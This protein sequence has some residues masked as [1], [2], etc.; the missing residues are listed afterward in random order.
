MERSIEMEIVLK[1]HT[2]QLMAEG[3]AVV[4]MGIVA[5]A[6]HASGVSLLL[7]PELAALSH[8]VISR[9]N[10][11]WA[12]Q[13]WLLILTPT[14]TAIVGLFLTRHASYGAIA[15]ALIVLL[16]LL[17]LKVFR[18]AIAPAISAGVL[19][20]VLGERSWVYPAAI[21]VDLASLVAVMLLW[22]RFRPRSDEPFQVEGNHSHL[23]DALEAP[24]RDRYW[25]FVLLSF[26]LL[27]GVS[28]QLSGLRYLLFPPLIV[29][30]YEIFGHPEVPGWMA[31]PAL[32]PLVCLLT[33]SLG[34]IACHAFSAGGLGVMFTMLASVG[35]LRIFK[36]HMP[37]ALAVG[38]LP[39]VMV[40]PNF[41][42]PLSVT[43]GTI[44]LT[45]Y[46][47]GYRHLRGTFRRPQLG[48]DDTQSA[49]AL[50]ETES[51]ATPALRR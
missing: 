1:R 47:L 33:A 15:I 18:S 13:P 32:F 27:L 50:S 31:R 38:L 22:R 45:L 19:P 10:G 49:V 11:K 28:A 12:S 25:L 48:G 41:W 4:Y 42:Y 17:V 9:P 20:M 16:S 39:F 34:T 44:V 23:V 5:F 2:V 37:P 30:A 6:A 24:P 36:V 43:I 3:L 35:I 46:S 14:S 8:D 21:F 7:F 40:S 51:C 26:V 29:M